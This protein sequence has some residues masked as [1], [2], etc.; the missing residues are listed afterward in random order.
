MFRAIGTRERIIERNRYNPD[1]KAER[2][3]RIVSKSG[4][5]QTYKKKGDMIIYHDGRVE[6]VESNGWY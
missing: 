3:L 5:T 2:K 1:K 4:V 6:W